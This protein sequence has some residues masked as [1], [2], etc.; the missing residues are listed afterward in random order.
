VAL[1][2][3]LSVRVANTYLNCPRCGLAIARTARSRPLAHCPRCFG[4]A[5]IRVEMFASTLRAEQL[6]ANGALSAERYDRGESMIDRADR[7]R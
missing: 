1:T 4:R 6:Y 3:G 5:R 2:P 7:E